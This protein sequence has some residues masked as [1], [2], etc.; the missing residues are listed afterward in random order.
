MLHD[1]WSGAWQRAETF[2]LDALIAEVNNNC[3]K[4]E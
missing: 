2:E 1:A 4:G 3:P